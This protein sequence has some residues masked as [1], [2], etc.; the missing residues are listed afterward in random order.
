M[1][2]RGYNRLKPGDHIEHDSGEYLGEVLAVYNT[3][4]RFTGPRNNDQGFAIATRH[5]IRKCKAPKK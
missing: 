4:V 5:E 2:L 3:V 1:N